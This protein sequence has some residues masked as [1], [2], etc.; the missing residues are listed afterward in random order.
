[1]T[2]Q[3]TRSEMLQRLEQNEDP[4]DVS[5]DKW[6]RLRA[7]IEE[8]YSSISDP[9]WIRTLAK[10]RGN[11]CAL[12]EV[13]KYDHDRYIDCDH[14]ILTGVDYICDREYSTWKRFNCAMSDYHNENWLINVLTGADNMIT[15]LKNCK[16]V[17]NHENSYK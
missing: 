11:T 7:W 6:I 9:R 1:M 8:T 17:D 12:C 10:Y 15:D 3:M 14:C 5:I 2:E 4:I 16:G 13:N